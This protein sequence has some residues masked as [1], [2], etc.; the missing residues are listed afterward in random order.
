MLA[1]INHRRFKG[2]VGVGWGFN[3]FQ[4]ITIYLL[5]NIPIK[6]NKFVF[7]IWEL[8]INKSTKGLKME[9]KIG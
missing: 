6:L 7:E 8:S 5:T 1:I 2:K 3:H 9:Q 4:L